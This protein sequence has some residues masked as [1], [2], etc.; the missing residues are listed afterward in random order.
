MHKIRILSISLSLI[1]LTANISHAKKAKAPDFDLFDIDGKVHRLSRITNIVVLNFFGTWCPPC[2][3]EIPDFVK[4]SKEYRDKGVEFIGIL[5][6]KEY[7]TKKIKNFI[8]TYKIKYPVLMA[9]F[10][11]LAD[12]KIKAYPTTFIIDENGYIVKKRVGLLFE[13]DL[14][15][16]I[17]RYL[18]LRNIKQKKDKTAANSNNNEK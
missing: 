15:E 10:G 2:R 16:I 5:V 17:E 1:F 4:V 13:K 12:Y 6:E 3:L 11:V 8:N 7:I 18:K 9:T 14:K